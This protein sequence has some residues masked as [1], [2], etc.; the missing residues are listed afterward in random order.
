MPSKNKCTT[1][2]GEACTE[3]EDVL[4]YTLQLIIWILK[5]FQLI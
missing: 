2:F 5:I 1:L 4:S 3:G